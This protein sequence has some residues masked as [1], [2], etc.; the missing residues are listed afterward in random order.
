MKKKQLLKLKQLTATEEMVR[1]AKE[2]IPVQKQG[3]SGY[4]Y[5]YGMHIMAE[6]EEKILKVA[7]FLTEYLSLGAA[8]PVYTIFVDKEKNDFIGYDHLHKKWTSAVFDRLNFTYAVFHSE[9]YCGD[10][11]KQCIQIY[12]QSDQDAEDALLS[13]QLNV[14]RQNLLKK[15]KILTD[16][17]DQVMR[18]V[19]KLPKKWEHWLKKSAL[20]QNFI[21]YEPS[22]KGT[23]HGYCTWCEKEVPVEHPKHNQ[24]GTCCCCRRKITYKSVKM[25]KKVIT[26]EETAYLVQNCGNGLVVREFRL[27]LLAVMSSYKKPLFQW[28]ERRRFVYDSNFQST[29]YYYGS[30]QT[31]R[32]YRWIQGE[33]KN[34]WGVGWR[35]YVEC[36]RGSVY[37]RNLCRLNQTMLGRTGLPEYIKG[38]SFVNPCEYLT[39]LTRQPVLEQI[40]KADLIQLAKEMV[41]TGKFVECRPSKELGK[42]LMV[43]R[44]RLNRLRERN[45]GADYLAW[46][47]F[48]KEQDGFIPDTLIDWM[49]GHGILPKD[50]GFIKD[51][52]SVQQVKNYLERQSA[53]SGESPKDLLTIWEDYL[54]MAKRSQ[55]DV[56]DPIIYRARELVRRHNELAQSVGNTNILRQAEELENSYPMLTQ[57][58][59]ELEKYEYSDKEYKIISPRRT[60]DIL[61]EGEKLRHCIDRNDRYFE[62]M[63]HRESYIL[64]L[65]KADDERTPYYTLEIEPNGTIRQ[66]RTLYN[67]QLDDIKEAE[68]FLQ[69]WQKQLQ[70]KLLQ[71]DYE[72]AKRS[73]VLRVQEME[74]LRKNKVRLNGNFQGKLLADVLAE[75]LMEVE[76][77]EALAA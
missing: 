31:E 18:E 33:L 39:Q 49:A 34:S 2:D 14:R 23:T 68:K 66:K 20:S 17:W 28:Y 12:L 43:D 35:Y 15:H 10:A 62:R 63:N 57:L 7:L 8:E 6:V 76:V 54:I 51:R 58:Y 77:V 55:I 26:E 16:K 21:F 53:E 47:R 24:K 11:S 42:S 3:Y 4:F 72:L 27:Q 75:D 5:Q 29:E 50:I 30:D 36:V 69:K 70:R 46:L 73:K 40:V 37:R 61:I 71:E 59:G 25:A 64:F 56:G 1:M 44:F 38:T 52:M 13:F 19:P 22:R 74:E 45:G 48:E 65:R 67:R 41:T 60:E 9:K 32:G